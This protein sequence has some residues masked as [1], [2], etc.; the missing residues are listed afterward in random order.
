MGK[1]D[2]EFRH[3]QE[4]LMDWFDTIDD[5]LFVGFV[6]SFVYQK[7]TSNSKVSKLIEKFLEEFELKEAFLYYQELLKKENLFYRA[8]S[9][10]EMINNIRMSLLSLAYNRFANIIKNGT[11]S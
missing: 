10:I 9:Q 8:P 3:I 6:D 2:D 11:N 4:D 1:K 5:K 7:G